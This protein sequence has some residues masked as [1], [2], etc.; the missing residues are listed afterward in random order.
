MDAIDLSVA[1]GMACRVDIDDVMAALDK[2]VD[3][4][5]DCYEYSVEHCE[6]LLIPFFQCSLPRGKT[7]NQLYSDIL[8]TLQRKG[9]MHMLLDMMPLI[10]SYLEYM[11]Q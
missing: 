7:H 6:L 5:I 8:A 10:D 11:C 9:K 3:I 4:I 1:F 2:D